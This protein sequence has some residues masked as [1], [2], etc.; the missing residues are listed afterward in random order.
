MNEKFKNKKG[1][2]IA[3]CIIF[4]IF[5]LII[6]GYF[7][8]QIVD[9]K[10]SYNKLVVDSIVTEKKDNMPYINIDSK[11]V[12]K[13]NNEIEELYNTFL[14]Y[15]N[16]TFN[17]EYQINDNILSIVIKLVDNNSEYDIPYYSII[18]YNINL[19]TQKN[20]DNN[21]LLNKFKITEEEVKEKIATQILSYYN[22]EVDLG[23]IPN[24]ECDYDFYLVI[25]NIND[26]DYDGLYVKNGNLVAYKSF[27]IN[28]LY[29][30]ESY[31]NDGAFEFDLK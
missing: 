27:Q 24:Q 16:N 25:H 28:S 10:I 23:Y 31:F 11:D 3:I 8:Y 21:Y 18:T 15:K 4:I 22:D 29:D 7:V 6:L 17:Y 2:L 30:D 19:K 13:I 12:K 20:I 26:F 5:L 1:Y 14:F 9:K